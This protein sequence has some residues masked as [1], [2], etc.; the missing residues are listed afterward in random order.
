MRARD[1]FVDLAGR[2]FHFIDRGETSSP[3]ILF[4][5]KLRRRGGCD[6]PV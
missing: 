4:L 2:R 1:D 6:A 3:A 5:G